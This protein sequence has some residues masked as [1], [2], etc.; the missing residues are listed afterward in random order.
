MGAR[1]VCWLEPAT[2]VL[3]RE[4]ATAPRGFPSPGLHEIVTIRPTHPIAAKRPPLPL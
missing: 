2:A 1:Y 4:L 3:F